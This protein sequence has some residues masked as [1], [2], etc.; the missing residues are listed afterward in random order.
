MNWYRNRKTATKL[1]TAV[2]V[3]AALMA[4]VGY[5]GLSAAGTLKGVL[6]ARH[7]VAA[8]G[9]NALSGLRQLARATAREVEETFAEF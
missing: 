3:M 2:A 9:G 6:Y 8:R 7:M 1:L 4:A 5:Q